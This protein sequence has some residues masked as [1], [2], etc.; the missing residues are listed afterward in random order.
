[1]DM[2]KVAYVDFDGT[3]VDVIP[4][5]F[6]ILSSYLKDK[7]STEL[8]LEKYKILK[9]RGLKDHQIVLKLCDNFKLDINDYIQYK[10]ENLESEFWLKRDVIIGSP[11]EAYNKL[12]SLGYRVKL[13]TQ[14]NHE[15]RL[16]DQVKRLGLEECF[17]D[18]IVVKPLVGGNAKV[19]ILKN[20]VN[21]KDIIIGDSSIE[22]ECARYFNI[23]GYFVRT[24][25]W[26]DKYA[27]SDSL[28]F[29]NYNSVVDF[30]YLNKS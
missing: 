23:K 22:M 3:V 7:V 24:G 5:Y 8:N 17:D 21:K 29:E 19:N 25:L 20:K 18:I 13:L 12:K 9:R 4:R 30:L 14:R 27:N 10:R 26:E 1:M 16:L 6:G 11:R 28:I 2:N 15:N